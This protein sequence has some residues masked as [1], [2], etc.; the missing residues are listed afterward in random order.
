MRAQATIR[1]QNAQAVHPEGHSGAP[2]PALQEKSER[3]FRRNLITLSVASISQS[4][5]LQLGRGELPGTFDSVQSRRLSPELV[6]PEHHPHADSQPV[7]LHPQC[8]GVTPE[9]L[10]DLTSCALYV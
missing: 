7:A 4:E 6:Q 5:R 10:W 9:A 2:S 1:R 3:H 8:K